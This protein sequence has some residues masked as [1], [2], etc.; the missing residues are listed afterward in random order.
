ML[1]EIL[2]TV[3]ISIRSHKLVVEPFLIVG[4]IASIRRMLV[5]TLQAES[6]TNASHWSTESKP[7]FEASIIELG[8]LALVIAVL[9]ATIVAAYAHCRDQQGARA[10]YIGERLRG[11]GSR[12][13]VAAARLACS[14][15][16]SSIAFE[17]AVSIWVADCL[18]ARSPAGSYGERSG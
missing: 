9:V 8:V 4:L 13:R 6:M 10:L 15:K 12:E 1:V 18:Y 7:L 2:H 16:I 3:R 5:L 11:R 14:N 17:D